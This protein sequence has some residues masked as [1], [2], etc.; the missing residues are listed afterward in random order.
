M[1]NDS[2]QYAEILNKVRTIKDDELKDWTN[3][4]FIV[5][6]TIRYS[7]HAG[8]KSVKFNVRENAKWI[9]KG[10]KR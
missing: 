4:A 6:K 1:S 10:D 8:D 7:I 9:A 3:E 5:K 2:N